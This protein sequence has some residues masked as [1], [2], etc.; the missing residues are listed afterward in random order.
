MGSDK[1][2]VEPDSCS[3]SGK[4]TNLRQAVQEMSLL[5]QLKVRTGGVRKAGGQCSCISGGTKETRNP[6]R[7]FGGW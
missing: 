4:L 7:K 1:Y 3:G 5:T 6:F 2:R